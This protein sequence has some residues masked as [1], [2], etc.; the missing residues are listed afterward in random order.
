MKLAILLIKIEGL[1]TS[2]DEEYYADRVIIAPGRDGSE[3]LTKILQKYDQEVSSNQVDIGVRVETLDTIM[4]EINQN[5]YEGKFIYRTS[6]GTT[7][8]SFL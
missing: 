3:W 1:V 7:V 5:L 2:K 4:E 6:V 8:R